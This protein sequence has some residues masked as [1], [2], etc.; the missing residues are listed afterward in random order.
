MAQ[1]SFTPPSRDPEIDIL[2]HIFAS[3]HA[4]SSWEAQTPKFIEIRISESVDFLLKVHPKLTHSV[5][6]KLTT[7]NSLW[8]IPIRVDYSLSDDPGYV[9]IYTRED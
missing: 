6:E 1:F 7:P 9:M 5:T 3:K 4:I 8:G 2:Q